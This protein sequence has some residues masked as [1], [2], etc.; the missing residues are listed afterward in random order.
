[1]IKTLSYLLVLL[2]LGFGIYYF[3]IRDNS[4][5]FGSSEAGFTIKDTA[6]VGKVFLVTNT[7][8][9]IL[10][11]RSND[12]WMVNKKYKALPSMMNLMLSTLAEQKALYPVTKAAQENAMKLLSTLGTKVEVYDRSNK[13]LSV[14]YVGR[15]A[16]NNTGTNMIME[17]AQVPYVVQ[18][19]AFTGD[20]SP[21][22]SVDLRDWRDRTVFNIAPEDI[23]SVSIQYPGTPINSF[24]ISRVG[25]SYE[26]KGDPSVT[27]ELDTLHLTRANL[28]MSYFRNVNCEG[29]MNGLQGLDTGIATTKKMSTV[30]VETI[31]NGNK[32]ID[33]YWMPI[34]RRS[35]NQQ[36]ADQD[37][38]DD[39]DADRMFAIINGGQDTVMIQTQTF[40]KI[41]RKAFEFYQKSAPVPQTQPHKRNVIYSKQQ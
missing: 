26:V 41:F 31:H 16:I 29:I 2:I 17:N 19:P 21:R 35:K 24:V 9:S 8:E 38:P 36:T 39:Y 5:P 27:T 14:F 13:K 7:G 18:T 23:K 32:H 37:V 10:L 40:K 3:I 34:N 33:V 28:Y 12:G 30:D 11:E 25:N 4:N 1:M 20:L 22:Y 15:G 6:S